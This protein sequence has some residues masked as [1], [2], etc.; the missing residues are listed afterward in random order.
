MLTVL[1]NSTV[2][3]RSLMPQPSLA[4][5]GKLA[6]LPQFRQACEILFGSEQARQKLSE[7]FV[8]KYAVAYNLDEG[9]SRICRDR[10]ALRTMIRFVHL[11]SLKP[12]IVRLP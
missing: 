4:D 2:P 6:P 7:F 10:V 1:K 3:S 9:R 12:I 5:I 8:C 11:R